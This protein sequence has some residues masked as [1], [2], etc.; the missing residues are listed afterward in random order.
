MLRVPRRPRLLRRVHRAPVVERGRG[1]GGVHLAEGGARRRRRP[2]R[3]CA[4]EL[5][6][7]GIAG[8]RRG[9]HVRRYPRR[10][11]LWS[12]VPRRREAHAQIGDVPV[13]G[14]DAQA[15]HTRGR[16]PNPRG[17]LLH[18]RH[19]VEGGLDS[20]EQFSVPARARQPGTQSFRLEDV[21]R[22]GG[23]G[24]GRVHTDADAGG[25]AGQGAQRAAAADGRERTRQ[26]RV[27]AQ[28]PEANRGEG[29]RRRRWMPSG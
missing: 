26:K 24:R 19:A 21:R 16:T 23:W 10:S 15:A 7:Q 9:S 29:R 25:R 3:G 11:R 18:L 20:I 1:R 4:R 27:G 5:R 14:E 28:G 6:E 8:A 2:S 12:R 13:G 17:D 22:E